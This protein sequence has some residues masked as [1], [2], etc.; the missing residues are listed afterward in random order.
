MHF[1]VFDSD[2]PQ[3]R[4]ENASI[5]FDD[6]KLKASG[7]SLSWLYN[8]MLALFHDQIVTKIEDRMSVALLHD[9]PAKLNSYL[10]A[11]PSTVRLPLPVAACLT[12]FVQLAVSSP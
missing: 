10:T 1:S 8:A 3:L 7:S 4:V 11:L 6:I 2:R 5:S 12:V 9:V